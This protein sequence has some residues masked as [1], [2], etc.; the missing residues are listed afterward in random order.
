MNF[1][2]S[3][4]CLVF[5]SVSDSFP[6]HVAANAGEGNAKYISVEVCEDLMLR[7]GRLAKTDA[8][9]GSVVITFTPITSPLLHQ[10]NF[11]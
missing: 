5:L 2:L 11:T 8:L 9:Y 6:P 3:K 7:S 4:A 10:R 1:Q